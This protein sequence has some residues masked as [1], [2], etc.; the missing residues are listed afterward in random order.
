MKLICIGR[1]YSEHA[2]ELNNPVPEEP[3]FFMK[4]DTAVLRDNA[5]FY[6][7][8]FSNDIHHEVELVLRVSKAGNHI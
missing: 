2:K 8:D 6:H 3:V 7:P 5:P 4:P 1:N